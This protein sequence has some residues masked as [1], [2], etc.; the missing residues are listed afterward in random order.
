MVSL[1]PSKTHWINKARSQFDNPKV[2]FILQIQPQILKHHGYDPDEVKKE[3]EES[4][5]KVKKLESG[6]LDTKPF[7]QAWL[8]FIDLYLA[9]L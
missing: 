4:R 3:I 6:S 9:N 1:G 2:H 7:E 5:K 8:S